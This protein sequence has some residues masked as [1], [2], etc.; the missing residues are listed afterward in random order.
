MKAIHFISGLPRSGSTLLRQ[1]PR[2]QAGMS[3]PLA[4]LFGA[5]LDEMG[6]AQRVFGVHR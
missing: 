3:G 5:L 1:N 2:F 6:V 4:G